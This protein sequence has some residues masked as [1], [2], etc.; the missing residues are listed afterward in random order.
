M[1]VVYDKNTKEVLQLLM[2]SEN[3]PEPKLKDIP[4]LKD[5]KN[6]A[7]FTLPNDRS[8]DFGREYVVTLDDEGNPT[9]LEPKPEPP[10]I[11]LTTSAKDTDSD[12][13]PEI[14]ANGKS[15]ATITATIKDAE[16]NVLTH[17][18]KPVTFRTT[19]GILSARNVSLTGGKANV[20][21]TSILETVTATVTATAEECRPAR[22]NIEFLPVGREG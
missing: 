19:R 21:L 3:V 9:R 11:E 4:S 22:I 18:K 15:K 5:M 10:I 14:P 1:L 8:F 6:V 17:V 16:G 13:L 20:T 7:G 2:V 12:G